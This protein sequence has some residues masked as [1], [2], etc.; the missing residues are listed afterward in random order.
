MKVEMPR[1]EFSAL[2]GGWLSFALVET[3]LARGMLEGEGARTLERWSRSLHER[4]RDLKSDLITPVEWQ[5]AVEGLLSGIPLADLLS[6]LDFT[7]LSKEI[8][9]PDVGVG[10]QPVRLPRLEGAPIGSAVLSKIFGMKRGRAIIPHGHRNMASAHLVLA[11]SLDLRQYDRIAD[12]GSH[13]I[14]SPT[15]E[16]EAGAGSVSSISDQKNNVHWFTALS[17]TAFTLDVIVTDLNGRRWDVENIDPLAGERLAG[18]RLR[19]P[20]LGVAEG[21]R[22]YGNTTHHDP[23]GNRS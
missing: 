15:L 23:G 5:A 16:R 6:Y 9:L 2:M 20:K 13:M 10:N 14:I 17:E 19:V 3:L 8:D 12:E 4:C 1:R 18:D 11:G 22:K 21:L 7:K